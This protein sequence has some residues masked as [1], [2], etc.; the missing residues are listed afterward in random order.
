MAPESPNVHA[1]RFTADLIRSYLQDAEIVPHRPIKTNPERVTDQRVADRHFVEVRQ[2]PKQQ[3]V[4]EIE[5]VPGVDAEAEGVRE[6]GG[7]T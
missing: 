7:R 3:Q 4:L 5:V 6:L 2:G 1:S